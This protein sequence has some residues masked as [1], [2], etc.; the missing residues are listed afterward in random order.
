MRNRK[1]GGI[2]DFMVVAPQ[3]IMIQLGRGVNEAVSMDGDGVGVLRGSGAGWQ[4]R[5]FN[6]G[7][8]RIFA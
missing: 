4:R 3:P 2:A 8:C 1:Q 6:R 7:G 5:E